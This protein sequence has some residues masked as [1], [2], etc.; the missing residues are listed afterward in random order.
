MQNATVQKFVWTRSETLPV[1][2]WQEFWSGETLSTRAGRAAKPGTCISWRSMTGTGAAAHAY[3]S[4]TFPAD[5]VLPTLT[6]SADNTGWARERTI[7]LAY[8]P[9]T[10]LSP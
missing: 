8:T 6:A 1:N 7:V 9:R 3:S 10:P 5:T 2:G 4:F